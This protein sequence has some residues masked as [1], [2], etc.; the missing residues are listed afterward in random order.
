MA[1]GVAFTGFLAVGLVGGLFRVEAALLADVAVGLLAFR[2]AAVGLFS[3]EGFV[4]GAVPGFDEGDDFVTVL[5][6][7]ER[8]APEA[9]SS[10][11]EL[12]GLED[13]RS[14]VRQDSPLYTSMADF[15]I[16]RH[17]L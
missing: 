13:G 17:S 12:C 15:L 6:M 5:E 8:S 11:T 4:V 10:P 16:V 14:M 1:R 2:D 7:F 9:G 3:V